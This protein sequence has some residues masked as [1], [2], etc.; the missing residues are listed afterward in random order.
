MTL[1]YSGKSF[2]KVV[3]KADQE[4]WARLHEE[5][6]RTF[7]G[8]IAYVVLDSCLPVGYVQKVVGPAAI[9]NKSPSLLNITNPRW[10]SVTLPIDE[11]W[12]ASCRTNYF[13][14]APSLSINHLSRRNI[15]LARGFRP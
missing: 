13:R 8:S 12:S 2:R 3:W 9:A 5:A 15:N 14:V 7:G 1:K 10:S 4:S 6:F 11:I